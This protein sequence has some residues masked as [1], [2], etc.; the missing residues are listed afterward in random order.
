MLHPVGQPDQLQQLF[1]P[2]APRPAAD[3]LPTHGHFHILQGCERG[4]QIVQLKDKAH[5]LR[6]ELVQVA[7]GGQVLVSD[8]HLATGGPVQPAKHI[9]QRALAAA[10]RPHDSHHLA[11]GDDQVHTI[12][13][14]HLVAVAVDFGQFP[15]FY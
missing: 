8:E 9:Q 2:L 7:D 3:G 15:C 1:G 10:R 4:Q 5:G 6:P 14:S 13:G 12:Q 11:L